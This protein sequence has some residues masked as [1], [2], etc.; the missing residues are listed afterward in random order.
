MLDA[1]S[2]GTTRFRKPK[3]LGC[4]VPSVEER[5]KK[6]K[7]KKKKKKINKKKKKKR[8]RKTKLERTGL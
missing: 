8:K 6:K 7:K 2:E 4:S 1:E 3:A 5:R